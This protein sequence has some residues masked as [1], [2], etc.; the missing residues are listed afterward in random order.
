MLTC[1][2]VCCCRCSAPVFNPPPGILT[3]APAHAPPF[4]NRKRSEHTH[5]LGGGGVGVT[6]SGGGGG[7]VSGVSGGGHTHPATH[8]HGPTIRLSTPTW[9]VCADVKIHYSIYALA[10]GGKKK[11][12]KKLKKVKTERTDAKIHHSID[13]LA[14]GGQK[15]YGTPKKN[16]P[17]HS[18][19]AVR[20]HY[21]PLFFHFFSFFPPCFCSRCGR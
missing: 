2:D 6:L 5:T 1:S 4:K 15:K 3:T 17:K 7:S 19:R 18:L 12:E 20:L 16:K 11:K 8:P 9:N 14:Q 13:V 21:F 10:D